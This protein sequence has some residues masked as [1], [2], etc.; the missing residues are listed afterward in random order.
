M[1]PFW[2]LAQELLCAPQVCPLNK[3]TNKQFA[4][5]LETAK[6]KIK[7]WANLTSHEELFFGWLMAV[8]SLYLHIAEIRELE[9]VLI[10]LLRRALTLL[11]RDPLS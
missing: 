11:M 7:E 6:S 3:Q 10:S 8:F 9:Q 2:S 1:A 5:V 4:T